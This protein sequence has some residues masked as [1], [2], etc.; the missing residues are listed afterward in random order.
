MF[1]GFLV[2]F[3]SPVLLK[4][5]YECPFKFFRLNF[6]NEK[7]TFFISYW[8]SAKKSQPSCKNFL[9]VWQNCYLC[10]NWNFW[11]HMV[12]FKKTFTLV[13]EQPASSSALFWNKIIRG[14]RKCT[15][16]VSR[17]FLRKRLL[18]KTT[19]FLNKFRQWAET[20]RFLSQIFQLGFRY[21]ILR[22]H[23]NG[24]RENTFREKTGYF[25]SSAIWWKNLRLLSQLVRTGCQTCFQLVHRNTL[26]LKKLIET[27]Y[28][29]FLFELCRKKLVLRQKVSAVRPKLPSACPLENFEHK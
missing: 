7:V 24:F 18:R 22:V 21:C 27:I 5:L 2:V 29:L 10:V 3:F 19:S 13:F 9:H 23:W 25:G 15:L 20:F 11:E 14:C 17:N 12:H 1:F 28:M 6:W 8:C 16:R 26:K 4:L